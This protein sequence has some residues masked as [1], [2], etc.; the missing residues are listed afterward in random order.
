[1]GFSSWTHT[2]AIGYTVLSLALELEKVNGAMPQFA[3]TWY[4]L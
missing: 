1:M 2:G 3:V 4:G